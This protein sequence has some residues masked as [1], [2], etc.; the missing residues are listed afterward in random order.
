MAAGLRRYHCARRERFLKD[1]R[2]L[3][4]APSTAANRTVDHLEAPDFALR[5]KS[6][7]KPRHKTTLQIRIV[8]LTAQAPAK[9]VRS[10]RRL[11]RR[12][13]WH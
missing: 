7:V 3:I 9:E 8:K 10:G 12:R 13:A 6:T 2:P 11:P 4:A 1:P 5:L